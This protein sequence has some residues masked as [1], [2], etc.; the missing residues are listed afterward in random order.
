[1]ARSSHHSSRTIVASLI[2]VSL[3]LSSGGC[4]VEE[5]KPAPPKVPDDR[6]AARLV[7]DGQVATP[8]NWTL[9]QV[10]DAGM[11]DFTATFVNSV[12]TTKTS[13]FTGVRIRTI[14]DLT[15][16]NATAEILEVEASDG[17]IATIFL[18]DVTATT[19]LA[20][21]EEGQWQN[22]SDQGAMRLV[23]T[24]MGSV[25]WVKQVVALHLKASATLKL[26]GHVYYNKPSSSD[27]S[28]TAGYLYSHATT[29]VTWKEGTKTRSGRGMSW[30]ELRT[31]VNITGWM[32]DLVVP[33][34][35][36][37]VRNASD[38]TDFLAIDSRGRFVYVDDGRLLATGLTELRAL[39]GIHIHGNVTKELNITTTDIAIDVLPSELVIH[40]W[41]V[42]A[43]PSLAS[44][45]G[46]AGLGTGVGS[47]VVGPGNGTELEIS[48]DNLTHYFLI[49]VE[50]PLIDSTY[51]AVALVLVA[52]DLPA[53]DIWFT[54]RW[55]E[56]MAL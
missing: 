3:V 2:V 52:K 15:H 22:L 38:T 28:I 20:L 12:G 24:Q 30:P 35:D 5:E 31:G 41:G 44:V 55:I 6:K 54:V 50:N 37:I 10:F 17:Y 36:R 8:L 29:N 23:D 4:L 19:Y 18:S 14:L 48:V 7:V 53:V 39:N 13:N 56:V 33:G 16:L 21:K 32:L 9:E 26:S 34:K 45:I 46:L 47:V 49:E 27:Q 11:E 25:Y 51:P 40:P 42:G 1:M 43:G